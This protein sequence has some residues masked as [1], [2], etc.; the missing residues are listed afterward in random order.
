MGIEE[1]GAQTQRMRHTYARAL[2]DEEL[3]S[4]LERGD[5]ITLTDA[6][7]DWEQIERQVERLGFGDTYAVSR[8]SRPDRAG[9]QKHTR[10]TPLRTSAQA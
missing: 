10:I 4:H 9:L 7:K 8:G 3:R 5:T 2:S 1:T 6:V